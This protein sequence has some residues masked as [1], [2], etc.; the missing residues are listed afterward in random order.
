M[1]LYSWD[2]TINHTENEDEKKK[3]KNISH[4]YNINRP[5]SRYR[6]KYSKYKNYL[7]MMMFICIKQHVMARRCG[8]S[9][10]FVSTFQFFVS[11]FQFFVIRFKK[12]L[13]THLK[14]MCRQFFF[15]CAV[16]KKNVSTVFFVCIIVIIYVIF[17]ILRKRVKDHTCLYYAIIILCNYYIVVS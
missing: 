2:Y 12:K 16:L 3:K 14:K 17:N 13:S 8:K 10:I 15:V 7:S 11:T 9:M 4:L 5:R 6:H 1:C